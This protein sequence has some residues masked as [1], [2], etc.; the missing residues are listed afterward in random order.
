MRRSWPAGC[1]THHRLRS[2]NA[3]SVSVATGMPLARESGGPAHPRC[4]GF[5]AIAREGLSDDQAVAEP[6][7]RR[8][9]QRTTPSTTLFT[10]DGCGVQ[11]NAAA[12]PRSAGLHLVALHLP[13]PLARR[14]DRR[15]PLTYDKSRPQGERRWRALPMSSASGSVSAVASAWEE[16][17]LPRAS[18]PRIPWQIAA[19]RK[20][21]K[22][23]R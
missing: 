21:T 18:R 4:W 23:V 22:T 16:D 6:G 12:G 13:R 7:Q 17:A 14:A 5:P 9:A 8:G 11:C 3:R 2:Y 1:G 15:T 20:I 10:V 19:R